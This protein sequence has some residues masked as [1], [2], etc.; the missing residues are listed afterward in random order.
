MKATIR[1]FLHRAL[2]P[3]VRFVRYDRAAEVGYRAAL[4]VPLFGCLAFL[5]SDSSEW[6]YDW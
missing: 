2:L 3:W 1:K 5:P 4:H 6:E